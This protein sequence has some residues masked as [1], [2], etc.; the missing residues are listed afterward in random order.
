MHAY[1]HPNTLIH[2]VKYRQIHTYIHT[3]HACT[4]ASSELVKYIHACVHTYIQYKPCSVTRT[5]D[6]GTHS[7]GLQSSHCS[8]CADVVHA[9]PLACHYSH[10]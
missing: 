4:A 3:I 6:P 7:D 9:Y 10:G 2:I 8:I 1:L 5:G